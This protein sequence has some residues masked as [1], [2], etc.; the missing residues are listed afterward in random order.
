MPAKVCLEPPDDAE[1]T[2]ILDLSGEGGP[3]VRERS[4]L[5][6]DGMSRTR[7]ST[8][9][10]TVEIAEFAATALQAA[11][12]LRIK[13][14]PLDGLDLDDGEATYLEA[15]TRKKPPQ[16]V[17]ATAKLLLLIADAMVDAK[18]NDQFGMLYLAMKLM[19]ALRTTIH[20]ATEARVQAKK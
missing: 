1:A 6:R 9:S 19:V 5:L 3:V 16:T 20:S 15:L 18:P 17:A 11:Q 12:Q 8:D 4:E 14:R 10:G 7:Q 2:E 13:T